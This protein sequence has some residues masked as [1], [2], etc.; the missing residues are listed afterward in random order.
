MLKRFQMLILLATVVAGCGGSEGSSGGTSGSGAG[1]ASGAG[2]SGGAGGSSSAGSSAAGSS[3]GGTGGLPCKIQP[4]LA[5]NAPGCGAVASIGKGACTADPALECWTYID[6]GSDPCMQPGYVA[7]FRCCSGAW[8]NRNDLGAGPCP[9][10][11]G[12]SGG[13]AGAGN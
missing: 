6:R 7:G 5:Y 11:T 2:G 12:G 9:G 8:V 10:A 1:G 13:S 4:I 3:A